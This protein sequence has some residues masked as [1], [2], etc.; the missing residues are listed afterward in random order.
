ML[1][2]LQ[3]TVPYWRAQRYVYYAEYVQCFSLLGELFP[4]NSFGFITFYVIFIQVEFIAPLFPI[5]ASCALSATVIRSMKLQT[6]ERSFATRRRAATL[7]IVLF[8]LLYAIF[9]IPAVAYEILGAV[10]M[11]SSGRF[12]FF[13]WDVGHRYF[14]NMICVVSVALNAACNPAL[15]FWRMRAMRASTRRLT[16]SMVS[17]VS[18]QEDNSQPRRRILTCSEI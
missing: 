4:Y 9:N 2:V 3:A 8:A 11:Y 1:L 15:Y 7:T 17:L 14:R 6:N 12:N 18:R 10:D 5:L 13:A 16:Q